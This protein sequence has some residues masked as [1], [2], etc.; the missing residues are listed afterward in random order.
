MP[1]YV[2]LRLSWNKQDPNYL[3][4]FAMDSTEVRVGVSVCVW[5]CGCVCG[6]D[7]FICGCDTFI[8]ECTR[9]Y[10]VWEGEE[11]KEA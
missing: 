1:V 9:T 11:G 10:N 5:V 7:T 6:C 2:L 3:A 4:T 8:C